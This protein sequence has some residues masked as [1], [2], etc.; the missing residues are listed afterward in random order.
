VNQRRISRLG[1]LAPLLALAACQTATAP[2]AS[3]AAV[4]TVAAPTVK[5][6]GEHVIAE[7]AVSSPADIYVASGSVWVAEHGNGKTVR[8]DPASNKI[9][10]SGAG[11]P[12]VVSMAT[13]T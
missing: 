12:P 10:A 13:S 2:S 7:W 9:V 5:P 6:L 8:I 11:D 4:P 3:P 1:Y